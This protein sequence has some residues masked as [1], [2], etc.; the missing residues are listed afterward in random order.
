MSN[1]IPPVHFNFQSA[2]ALKDKKR[3]KE[4]ISQLIK[5]ENKKLRSLNYVFCS[6]EF[7]LQINN[8]FLNHDDYTDIITFELSHDELI[9]GEIYI[10]IERIKEN[11]KLYSSSFIQ[12]LRRVMFH[13]ALHLCGYGDKTKK[14]KEIMTSK[15]NTYLNLWDNNI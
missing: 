4:F 13:G 2:Y 11:A 6:D 5:M 3:L 9:E 10:S 14:D 1:S 7:L 15:E 8:D 12:E